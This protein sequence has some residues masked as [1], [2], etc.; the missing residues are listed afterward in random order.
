[1]TVAKRVR[2]LPLGRLLRPRW[3]KV[4]SPNKILAVAL[5]L[6]CWVGYDWILR[7]AYDSSSRFVV[8]FCLTW[9]FVVF[10]G[11]SFWLGDRRNT[12]FGH[13]VVFVFYFFAWWAAVLTVP[14]IKWRW[15]LELG[16]NSN[17]LLVLFVSSDLIL[18]ALWF[19]KKTPFHP[20][21]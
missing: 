1:M 3:P 13:T 5:S 17:I 11:I 8:A 4:P 15:L 6:V 20:S 19:W 18:P 2:G 7:N 9:L 21:T 12:S 16:A 10:Q 14:T